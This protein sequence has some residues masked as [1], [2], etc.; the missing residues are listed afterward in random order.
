MVVLKSIFI[1]DSQLNGVDTFSLFFHRIR[2]LIFDY[3][4]YYIYYHLLDSYDV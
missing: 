4:T 2:F 3:K 1:I